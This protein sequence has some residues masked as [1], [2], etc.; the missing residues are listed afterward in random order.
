MKITTTPF[1]LT[2]DKEQV[3]K[4]SLQNDKGMIVSVLNYGGIINEIIV[5]DKNGKYEN[6]VLGFDNIGDYEEKSPYF[7]CITGRTAGRISN[8][9]FVLDNKE[10]LLAKNNGRNNLHG[11]IK[12]FDKVVWNVKEDINSDSVI[13]SL[14]YLSKDMEEGFPGNLKVTVDYI[15][16]NDDELIINYSGVSDK[17][18]LINLTN[19]SYFNLSGNLKEDILKHK[20]TIKA[21]KVAYVNDEVVPTGIVPNVDGTV[22]DFTEGKLVGLDIKRDTEQIKNCG[23]YDHPFILDK[24]ESFNIRLEDEESKR[25]LEMTTDQPCVV[26]Y[27]GNFLEDDLTLDKNVK[28]KKHLGLCLETQDYPDAINLDCFPI[29]IYEKDEQYTA[30]TKYKFYLNV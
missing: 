30:H 27:S 7:G 28:S 29:K 15:L 11:G 14:T 8:S 24:T 12:G 9:R 6:V 22:F 21:S 18:T 4:Y 2:K 10:Y 19:H 20:L 13:L 25:I 17:K 1:G 16:N 23:G 5:K 3:I 26:F